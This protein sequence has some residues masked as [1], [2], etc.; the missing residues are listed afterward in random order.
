MKKL[1]LLA[2]AAFALASCSDNDNWQDDPVPGPAPGPDPVEPT[3]PADTYTVY[4]FEASEGWLDIKGQP[5]VPG[6]VTIVGGSVAG[7]YHDV[8]W[9]KSPD[10]PTTFVE[11]MGNVYDGVLATSADGGVKFGSYYLDGIEWGAQ[12]DTWGGFVVSKNFDRTASSLDLKNHFSAWAEKGAGG[13]DTFLAAYDFS[14]MGGTYT[15]PTIV[16]TMPRTVT[17]LCLANSTALYPYESSK[18]DFYFTVRVAG[19]DAAGKLLGEVDC[20]LV[21]DGKKADDWVE[22]STERLG[23]V[24][25]LKFKVVSNDAMAP[26]YFCLDELTLKEVVC[27]SFEA[28]EGLKDIE[29]QAAEPGDI[30]MAGASV[31]QTYHNVFWAKSITNYADYLVEGAY[32]GYLFSTVDENLWFGTCFSTSSFGDYWGGFVLTGN[33]GKTATELDYADQFTVWADGGADGSAA[34]LI[35]YEDT[36]SG[37]YACPKIEVAGDPVT[38]RH[39]YL[40]NT[41]LTANYVPTQV[42]AS[43]YYYKVIV[44]GS[45]DGET[46]GSVECMLVEGATKADDWKYVDLS[47]LGK[48]DCLTFSTDTNDRNAYGP[49]APAYFAVDELGFVMAG[50]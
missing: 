49:L 20:P 2:F 39:C 32:N 45:L 38:F 27:V 31:S 17:G 40:A 10:Y 44:T 25:S 50:K 7:V 16:F 14:M 19:Y 28:S 6:D 46:T 48:V 41:A 11:Y 33:F 36:Y 3:P 18:S 23:A 24:S 12:M 15:S 9:A 35:A 47:S 34:C 26:A 13:S 43:A 37:G 8:F 29:G 21:A 42:D 22:V 5:V 30:S 4:S 1:L